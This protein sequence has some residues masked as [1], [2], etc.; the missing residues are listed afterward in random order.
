MQIRYSRELPLTEKEVGKLQLNI[1][2]VANKF[3]SCN[4]VFDL[5]FV[6]F[7]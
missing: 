1:T 7:Q 3:L 4:E 2:W 6:L 5:N